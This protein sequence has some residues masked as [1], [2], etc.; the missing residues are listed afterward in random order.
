MNPQ[1]IPSL[2][3]LS[4]A[5]AL[6]LPS[7]VSAAAQKA[8]ENP[9]VEQDAAGKEDSRTY[10]NDKR[11]SELLSAIDSLLSR[12]A[13]ERAEMK[14]LP[15]RD[16]YVIPP[17]WQETREDRESKV[18]ELLGSVLE[19]VTEAPVIE[20]QNR[21]RQSRD[22]IS[23]MK[24]QIISLREERM[25]APKDGVLPGILSQTQSSIDEQIAELE[26]RI[27]LNEEAIG[28][29]KQDIKA[30][31]AG[32]GVEL[33]DDQADLL[34]DSVLGGDLI[35]LVTAFQAARSV[36]DQL[37]KL[38]SAS[39][40]DIKAA[41][42]YFAMHAALFA[43][44]VH[45]Q[46]LLI[47]KID[48]VYVSKL[49]GILADIRKTRNRTHQLLEDQNRTDQQRALEANIE[50]Q[51]FAEKVASFYRDYLLTQRRQIAEAQERTLRDLAIA[52]NTFETVEASFQL[53][54]LM[55]E[56]RTSFEALQKLEAPGFDQVFKNETLRRE[57]ENLTRKLGPTS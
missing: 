10:L 47:D 31:L 54:E 53:H 16:R 30:A 4:L 40:N 23:L 46:D 21:L 24:D 35:K 18:D 33:S 38:L 29:I 12:A 52:D 56:A 42:R 8:A 57:F 44:M 34:L 3:V 9:P 15:S 43:M 22:E 2:A 36:D 27:K 51:N 49:H 13:K 19:I 17:L 45:A 32:A 41:R 1:I 28:K 20:M 5:A 55:E 25:R 6:A 48:G 50:A 14:D 37:A 11:A 7:P 39:D 26:A